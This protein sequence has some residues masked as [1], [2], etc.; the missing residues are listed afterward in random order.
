MWR[1]VQSTEKEN[2]GQGDLLPYSEAE[3][4]NRN[5]R[6][7]QDN[8]VDQHVRDGGAEEE[9]VVVDAFAVRVR[10]YPS[11]FHGY[12]LEDGGEDN[13]DTPAGDEGEDTVAG[14]F[15]GFADTEEAVVEEQ[16]GDFDEGYADAVEDF[17]GDGGLWGV[18]EIV[19]GSE[20]EV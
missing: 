10:S 15:E 16:D 4:P 6:Q 20:R 8:N 5:H 14:V 18:L 9:S 1:N 7:H 12:A 17:V 11:G 13:G 2:R 3:T 19:Y